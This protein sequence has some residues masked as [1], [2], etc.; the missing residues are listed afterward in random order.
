MRL[1]IW[2][3]Y[4]FIKHKHTVHAFNTHMFILFIYLFYFYL[5]KLFMY[6]FITNFMYVFNKKKN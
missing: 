4:L 2:Q 1:I 6:T 5:F 3:H